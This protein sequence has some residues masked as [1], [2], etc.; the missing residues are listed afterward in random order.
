M[1]AAFTLQLNTKNVQLAIERLKERA[2]PAIA[3]ALNRAGGSAKTVMVRE[4]ARDLGLKAGDVR[5]EVWIVDATGSHLQVTLMASPK[6]IP[7][8]DF[9]AKQTRR[10]GVTA[11]LPTGRGRYPNA[12]IARMKSG[13]EGVFARVGKSRLPITELHGP[14]IARSFTKHVKVGIARGEEQLV[15]N[16]RSELKFAMSRAS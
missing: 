15:K 3:R 10:A 2:N 12:F 13:H 1:A 7:L 9:R 5:D 16:L 4:I 6:R 11:K 14:S 8:M